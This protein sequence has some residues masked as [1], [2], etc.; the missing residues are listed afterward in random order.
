VNADQAVSVV[1]LGNLGQT[2]A[3]CLASRGFDVY[4]IDIIPDVIDRLGAGATIVEPGVQELLEANRDRLHFGL[5]AAAAIDKSDVTFVLVATPSESSG[6][7]SMPYLEQSLTT[8]GELLGSSAKKDHLFIIGSTVS[9]GSA[10][11][12]VEVLETASAR[13][14][15]DGF[16]LCYCPELVALG[17]AVHGF[18]NPDVVI[19]GESSADAGAHADRIYDRL[20]LNQPEHLHMTL[21]EA[22]IAKLAL[23]C[24]LTLKISFGNSLSRLCEATPG[25]DVDVVSGAL[26]R[27]RRIGRGYLS[28]GLPFGGPCFPRDT[29]AFLEFAQRADV[30]AK[31]IEA[32]EQVNSSQLQHVLQVIRSEMSAVGTDRVSILGIAFKEASSVLTGSAGAALTDALLEQ[33]AAVTIFDPLANDA[34]R[35]RFG[36][37]VQ[38]A[39]TTAQAV[40]AS[41]VS[42]VTTRAAE[43]KSIDGAMFAHAP[44]AVIDCWRILDDRRLGQSCR[45][46]ALGR[47]PTVSS[48]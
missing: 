9:P 32:V 5:D 15:N 23:N 47:A 42:V 21:A 10:S 40:A 41:P 4:G 7:F 8:L 12:L 18:L 6:R 13:R 37:R 31:L 43:F 27:D 25:V 19:V 11:H 30:P 38:Y 44:S 16:T 17:N 2:L 36:D 24:Y 34:A 39:E 48:H 45:Y 46:R 35:G 1:G 26:E 3:M 14:L 28:G 22:E 33:G 20:C 29:A